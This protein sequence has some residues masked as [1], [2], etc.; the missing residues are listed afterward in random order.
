VGA[1]NFFLFGLTTDGIAE[2]R[3]RGYSPMKVYSENAAL[4]DVIDAIASGVFSG[5]DK[6]LFQPMVDSLL[7]DDQYLLLA[8]FAAYVDCQAQ[9]DALWADPAA[10]TRRSI[11][12]TA[13]MG[14]FSSDRSIREYCDL[15]WNV[16]PGATRQT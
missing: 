12:N 4:R 1:E 14:K 5:G 6:R 2:T 3:Q 11:L 13:R 10:W 7:G 15:I 16:K 9:V 8:D